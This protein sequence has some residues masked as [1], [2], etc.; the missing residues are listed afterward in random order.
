MWF[1]LWIDWSEFD[2]N[3]VLHRQF[4]ETISQITLPSVETANAL[5]KTV[6]ICCSW[7][8]MKITLNVKLYRSTIYM[9]KADS[10]SH[11]SLV[12]QKLRLVDMLQF[13][14]YI[15]NAMLHS[16]HNC[17]NAVDR[18]TPIFH[19]EILFSNV[20]VIVIIISVERDTP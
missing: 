19:Q 2:I 4:N 9:G 12:K 18:R 20:H 16:K 5:I 1:V 6:C 8:W 13:N 3:C 17:I 7:T 10:T 14:I 11:N 15:T